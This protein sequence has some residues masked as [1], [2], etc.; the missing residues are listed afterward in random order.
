M[1]PSL[2]AVLEDDVRAFLGLDA[3]GNTVVAGG[4]ASSSSSAAA[5]SSVQPSGGNLNS[6]AGARSLAVDMQELLALHPAA[7]SERLRELETVAFRLQTVGGD[8]LQRVGAGAGA[9]AAP[10]AAGGKATGGGAGGG[11]GGGV[12]MA[13]E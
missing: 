7:L 6:S 12:A 11:G 10:H 5:A 1:P 8:L 9:Q 13:E 2:P 3:V 4:G